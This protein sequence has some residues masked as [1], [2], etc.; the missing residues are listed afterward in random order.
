MATKGKPKL[1]NIQ[2]DKV[3]DQIID[4][5]NN[6][7]VLMGYDLNDPKSR[8]SILHNDLNYCLKLTYNEL[9]KPDKPLF[10]NQASLIDYDNNELLRVIAD[11]L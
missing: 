9:F 8:K 5:V 11:T 3:H 7:L 4:C 6:N 2:V 10:N 1:N